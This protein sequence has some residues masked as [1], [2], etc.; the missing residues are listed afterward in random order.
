MRPASGHC[1][2]VACEIE[3][4]GGWRRVESARLTSRAADTLRAQLEAPEAFGV[5]GVPAMVEKVEY[6]PVNF[7]YGYSYPKAIRSLVPGRKVVVREVKPS[8][9]L[10]VL[11]QAA[12]TARPRDT[13]ARA[14]RAVVRG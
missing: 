3:T 9:R 12:D 7:G 13:S 8:A 5:R 1:Y 14:Y 6:A 11:G 2:V 4:F 10:V